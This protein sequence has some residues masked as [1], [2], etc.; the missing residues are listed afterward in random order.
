MS[1]FL[2]PYV[3]ANW[4][5]FI[6][7]LIGTFT[8]ERLTVFPNV[9]TVQGPFAFFCWTNV[10]VS[11]VF[12]WRCYASRR[13]STNRL[14]SSCQVQNHRVIHHMNQQIGSRHLEKVLW[15]L[16]TKTHFYSWEVCKLVY[17]GI[18]LQKGP[19][20]KITLNSFS[21]YLLLVEVRLACFV[22]PV[23]W[24]QCTSSKGSRAW[25]VQDYTGRQLVPFQWLSALVSVMQEEC[26]LWNQ[27]SSFCH[28]TVSTWW[29][30]GL[31][32]HHWHSV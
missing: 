4:W 29:C 32:S 19:K 30:A 17:C 11:L 21:K 9:F 28:I 6:L 13:S 15:K 7:Y 18:L 31:L 16:Q 26:V 12:E 5:L 25:L 10:N 8:L 1:Q 24:M 23:L 2:N 3:W 22:V 20:L 14:V 27:L